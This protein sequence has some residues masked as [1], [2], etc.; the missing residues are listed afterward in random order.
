M[1]ES[2]FEKMITEGFAIQ[3]HNAVEKITEILNAAIDQTYL[4][5]VDME[6]WSSQATAIT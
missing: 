4:A 2:K 5:E 6:G 1:P 3:G